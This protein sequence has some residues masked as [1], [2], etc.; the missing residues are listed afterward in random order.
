MSLKKLIREVHRRSLWQVL[1]IYAAGSWVAYQVVVNLVEGLHLPDWL[2]GFALALFIIGLPIVLATA[3][4]QE[5]APF[6]DEPAAGAET[7]AA[8]VFNWKNAIVGG[9][10][11]FIIWG[12]IAVGYLVFRSAPADT[13]DTLPSVAV[14]P[15]LNMSADQENEYFSDGMTEELIN[16]LSNVTGLRVSSRTSSFVFKGKQ[17]ELRE[18]AR[19]L[20][21]GAVVE[22][23][24]R[25]AGERVRVTAQ[26]VNA[27][28]GYHLW[29][30]T[31]SRDLKDVFALQ[32]E[33]AREIANALE[34]KLISGD[35]ITSQ[36]TSDL[37]AYELY[38]KG[39]FQIDKYTEA[40]LRGA[41][42]LLNQAIRRDPNFARAYGTIAFAWILL[43]DDWV[44]PKLAY[45][46]AKTAAAKGMALDS[47]SLDV[48]NALFSIMQVYEW[49]SPRE[50]EDFARRMV[51]LNPNSAVGHRALARALQASGKFDAA[52]AEF[53]RMS[54]LDPV[55]DNDARLARLYLEFGRYDEATT[56]AQRL[57]TISLWPVVFRVMGDAQLAKGNARDALN[58][59]RRGLAID[60]SFVRLQ[61]AEARA[62]SALNQRAEATAILQSL[63]REREQ[64]YIRGEE[65]A[66]IYVALGDKD[67]AFEWLEQAYRD[68]SAGLPYIKIW[69]MFEPLHAD[70]RWASLVKRV[71]ID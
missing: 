62:L 66:S 57:L 43:A 60:S 37:E 4:V 22:G 26:L 8:K 34:V 45:P 39:R 40:S 21:V 13:V 5:R 55:L 61:T 70:S 10:A 31:Y 17:V 71:G 32:E 48:Q 24:V 67:K 59:Y 68:R 38:L 30:E 53:Q 58:T 56:E 36:G 52:L 16:A 49:K 3:F 29:S 15:F 1:G 2:P 14:L 41:I 64:R 6:V 54:Q 44:A 23:S 63:E 51:A 46:Q 18:I 7:P 19:K 25:K 11:A 50:L 20:N 9:V 69:P 28:D 35:R 12:L 33:L 27:A 42:D 65:I 47:T